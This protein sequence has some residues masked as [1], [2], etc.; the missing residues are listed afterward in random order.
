MKRPLL[1]KAAIK[2]H[3]HAFTAYLLS[4]QYKENAEG[5]I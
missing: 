3:K 5:Q 1:E 2:L 4:A